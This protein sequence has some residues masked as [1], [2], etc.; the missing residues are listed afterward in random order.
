MKGRGLFELY[1]E[2]AAAAAERAKPQPVQS[3]PQPGSIE[4]FE[5]QH[6]KG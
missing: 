2:Q 5:E 3:V 6:K 1:R 4:W